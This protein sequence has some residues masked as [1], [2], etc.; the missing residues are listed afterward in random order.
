MGNS[1][2][3]YK[4]VK[5]S[6]PTLYI[7]Q[8]SIC[9][10]Y[11]N[12]AEKMIRRVEMGVNDSHSPQSVLQWVGSAGSA[13]EL[14][15]GFGVHLVRLS[16]PEASDSGRPGSALS[17]PSKCR[18]VHLSSAPSQTSSRSWTAPQGWPPH[19]EMP[20]FWMQGRLWSV[21]GVSL[22]FS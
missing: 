13:V 16:P 22:L 17:S 9:Q 18:E 3:V 12:K 11:L 6:K 15:L 10:R 8:T 14:G 21:F 4:Y 2:T 5:S 1:F 7:A 20:L 19:W